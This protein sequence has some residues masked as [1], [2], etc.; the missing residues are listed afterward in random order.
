MEKKDYLVPT[1]V[2]IDF[3]AENLMITASPTISPGEEADDDDIGTRR[4]HNGGTGANSDFG[5]GLWED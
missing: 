1:V 4:Q 3:K 5:K 2:T